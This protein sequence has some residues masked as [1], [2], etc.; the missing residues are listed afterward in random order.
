MDASSNSSSSAREYYDEYWSGKSG[1]RPTDQLDSQLKDWID[2]C[3]WPGKALLDVG[4]GDGSRYA[5]YLL[6]RAFALSGID[7]SPE[8][9][10]AASERGVQATVAPLDRS[11][12]F[13]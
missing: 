10:R 3:T 12:P 5:P 13:P 11:L 2:H 8:A 6:Q 9:V 1:W 7:V 4:C